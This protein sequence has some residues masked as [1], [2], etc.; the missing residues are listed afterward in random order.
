MGGGVGVGAGVRFACFNANFN[1]H[2]Y[3]IIY[4]ISVSGKTQR[5]NFTRYN[6]SPFM[7]MARSVATG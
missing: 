7:A 5:W 4:M 2:V 3:D 6:T 1:I